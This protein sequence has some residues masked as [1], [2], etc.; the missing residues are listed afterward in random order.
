[1][2]IIKSIYSAFG[3]KSIKIIVAPV[4][5]YSIQSTLNLKGKKM[6]STVVSQ[7][8][9]PY[10]QIA[11]AETTLLGFGRFSYRIAIEKAEVFLAKRILL[12]AYDFHHGDKIQIDFPA[13]SKR[14]LNKSIIFIVEEDGIPVGTFSLIQDSVFG[15]PADMTF[16][17]ELN[18]YRSS[19]RKISEICSLGVTKN[20][21]SKKEMMLYIIMLSTLQ[22]LKLG[23]TDS[24]A[25]VKN[26]HK[27]FYRFLRFFEVGAESVSQRTASMVSLLV[28]NNK[29]ASKHSGIELDGSSVKAV[30]TK[31]LWKTINHFLL[32]SDLVALSNGLKK[33]NMT[34]SVFKSYLKKVIS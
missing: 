14:F 22:N 33:L 16:S 2:I 30:Q 10:K 26:S 29:M 32:Q 9:K 25:T 5:H 18:I 12:D 27:P 1:M 4:L 15:L 23:I 28:I 3:Q 19:I 24:V 6:K 8:I 11:K 7:I 21:V 13:E 20:C 17:K 31:S 34:K